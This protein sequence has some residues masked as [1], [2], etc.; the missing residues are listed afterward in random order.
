MKAPLKLETAVS[1]STRKLEDMAFLFKRNPKTAAE[2][3][4]AM[5]EQVGKLD[6][7]GDSR[8]AQEEVTRYLKHVREIMEGNT[9][10]SHSDNGGMTARLDQLSQLAREVY[11]TDCLYLL[12]SHLEQIEFDS[13][14]LVVLL[15]NGLLRRRVGQRSPTV[16]YLVER[17]Q[18]IGLLLRGPENPEISLSTGAMLR[19]ALQYEQISQIVLYSSQFWRYFDYCTADSFETSTDA[20]STVAELLTFHRKLVSSFFDTHMERF[21]DSINRLLVYPNYVTKRESVKLLSRLILT[22]ANY[23]LMT[24]YVSSPHNLKLIMILLGDK[25]RNIQL[26]AF[27]V[28]KV[29]VANPHKNKAITDILMKN[30]DKLLTFLSDF[31]TDHSKYDDL[32]VAEKAFVIDQIS[33]L[34]K[35]RQKLPLDDQKHSHIRY[36]QEKCHTIENIQEDKKQEVEDHKHIMKTEKQLQQPNYALLQ[37]QRL[38]K[39]Q[40]QKLPPLPPPQTVQQSLQYR[41]IPHFSIKTPQLR[42]SRSVLGGVNQQSRQLHQQAMMKSS[43]SSSSHTQNSLEKGPRLDNRMSDCSFSESISLHD[44]DLPLQKLEPSFLEDGLLS[45]D[46]DSSSTTSSPHR[47]RSQNHAYLNPQISA[48]NVYKSARKALI[49]A[50]ATSNSNSMASGFGGR[51]TIPKHTQLS[52]TS[53]INQGK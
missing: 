50:Q 2:L 38:R 8:K 18:I 49:S 6:G 22:K 4:R 48:Q 40:Q 21:I 37:Q 53:P 12:L 51:L 35:I 52:S 41:E 5:N 13:R 10:G 24:T 34:P 7:S 26:E 45:S 14:K 25:S 19:E 16:D 36:E 15:F 32:F 1:I 39:L 28:F 29:F 11:S 23:N 30:R 20:F 47:H 42:Q 27:N 9:S 3:V 17:P 33:K 44:H 31:N 46:E 43:S